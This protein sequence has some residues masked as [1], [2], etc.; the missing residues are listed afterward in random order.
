MATHRLFYGAVITPVSVHKAEFWPNALLHV[1][2]RGTIEWVVSDVESSQI[3]SVALEKG[4]VVDDS[5]DVYELRHGEWLMPGFIDTHTAS[6]D[7]GGQY[8]LLNWLNNVTF[9]TESRFADTEFAERV[10][11]SVVDRVL[12]SGTTTCCYY[13][14]LH[15]EATET[16]AKI[17]HN[18]GQ[19][20]FVGKCNM[21]RNSGSYQEDSTAQSIERTQKL[22][23]SIRALSPNSPLVHP[24]LTPRFAIS[25]TTDLLRA[26]GDLAKQDPTLAIQTHI[27]ENLSEIEFTRKLFPEASSYADVYKRA[28]LLT[29]RTILA[30][31]VH[32]SHEEMEMVKCCGSGIS[33]CPTSNFYLNSG[34][35]RVGEMLDRGLKARTDCSGGFS[36]SI[37]T[38][39]RDTG[40]ASKV[41]G[42]TAVGSLPS[43]YTQPHLNGVKHTTEPADKPKLANKT[44]PLSALLHLSTLGGAQLCNLEQTVGSLEAGKEFD[45]VWVSVRPEAGNAGIW[46]NLEKEGKGKGAQ[47]PVDSLEA[48]LE[49]F[50][51]CGDDRNVRKVWVRGRLVGGVDK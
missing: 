24:V 11:N 31:A 38:A 28:G 10:Y 47:M 3:Q 39:V 16:L 12:N 34:V 48:L 20:A 18:K 42:M 50:F 51:F 2:P 25:C 45:A 15:L 19:R 27:S 49:K 17:V 46:A 14:T 30:H 9:P 32:L 44:L 8:E 40:I 1:N 35:A 13:G 5:V 23:S 22:I 43:P 29:D 33:H 36:P 37:L 7:A 4:L 26:L 6:P 41:I 21:N